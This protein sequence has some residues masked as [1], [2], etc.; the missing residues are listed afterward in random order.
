MAF[1]SLAVPG[2]GMLAGQ[3]LRPDGA[4]A[5]QQPLR[6]AEHLDGV[7]ATGDAPSD[8]PGEGDRLVDQLDIGG[9]AIRVEVLFEADVE[10]PAQ[11]EGEAGDGCG[12]EIASPY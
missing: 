6:Q 3:A 8:L 12:H 2:G 10:M 11:F 5:N 1:P 7:I 4:A 9:L